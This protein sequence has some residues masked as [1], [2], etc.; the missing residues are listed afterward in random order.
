MLI[1]L[2]SAIAARGWTQVDFAISLKIPPTV[3]S[4]IIHERRRADVSLRTRIAEALQAEEAWLFSYVVRIPSPPQS[5]RSIAT[6]DVVA[7]SLQR[8]TEESERR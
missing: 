1:N 7:V 5:T 6:P 3:V 4:E 8:T 2:K